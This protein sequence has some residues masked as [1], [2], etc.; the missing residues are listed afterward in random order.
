MLIC[1]Q[2]VFLLLRSRSWASWPGVNVGGAGAGAV[3]AAG[4]V[5]VGG[6]GAGAGGAGAAEGSAAGG[7]VGLGGVGVVAD[8]VGFWCCC[9]CVSEGVLVWE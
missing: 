3:S 6:A 9:V 5:V 7:S 8:L 2:D 1:F 4:V